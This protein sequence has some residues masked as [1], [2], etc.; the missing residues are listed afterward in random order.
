MTSQEHY[1]PVRVLYFAG[2]GRSG[3]TVVTNIL[4]QLPGAFAAGELRYLWQR[5]VG[6]DHLCGCGQHFSTCPVWTAVMR[7]LRDGYSD[8]EPASGTEGRPATGTDEAGVGRRLLSRLRMARLPGML[9]R[10]ALGRPAVTYHADDV[11]IARL[12]QS[13]AEQTGAQVVIDSSKLPPYGLL[14]RQLP[15]VELYV[16]HLV[17]DPRATAYSWLRSK[18]SRDT[19][20]SGLMPRQQAWKSAFL[21]MV[22]N[23]TAA[24][25]WGDADPRVC[26]MRYEDFVL[27]PAGQLSRVATMVGA[28]PAA[29]P[30]LGPDRVQL[31]PTHCVAGNPNRHDSGVVRLSTDD[32]WR[33]AMGRRDRA[34]VTLVTAPGLRRFRYPL[35]TH[36]TPRPRPARWL[37]RRQTSSA[38]PTP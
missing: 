18:P 33:S 17:R 13:I 37:Q 1:A 30:F 11:P 32:E 23:L 35:R 20:D 6:Q 24:A 36:T 3:T 19:E 31:P 27:D 2:S 34:L 28:D 7:Q 15:G 8:E 9:V 14:L 12:Y 10:H 22:W 16:I 25:V 4:G 29:L 5:G 21:W 26:R 38:D